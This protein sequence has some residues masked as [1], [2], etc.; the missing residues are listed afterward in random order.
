V[1][2]KE[3]SFAKPDT[4]RHIIKKCPSCYEYLPLRAKVCPAC[5]NKVGDV[6]KLGFA[7]KPFDWMGYLFAVISIAVFVAFI[8]WAFFLE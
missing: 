4:P 1:D 6:D 5:Q 3:Q 2:P 8:W 7:G